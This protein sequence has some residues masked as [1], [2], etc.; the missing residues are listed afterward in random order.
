MKKL[1]K[2]D[3]IPLNKIGSNLRN[4]MLSHSGW[5]NIIKRCL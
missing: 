5:L 3:A 4:F 2:K 1:K